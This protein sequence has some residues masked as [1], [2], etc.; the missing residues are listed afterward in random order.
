MSATNDGEPVGI[1]EL[2]I[3]LAFS[4]TEH[5]GQTA[6]ALGRSVSSIQRTVRALE[7]RLGVPLV[8]RDGRRVRLLHAGR[9][10]A[11]HA[12]SVVRARNE[13]VGAV[14]AASTPRAILR[15]GH[16]FSLGLSLVPRIVAEVLAR[17][18]TTRLTLRHGATNALVTSLLAGELDAVLVSPLPLAADLVTVPLFTEPLLF[19]IAATDALAAH[20]SIELAAVRDRAFVALSE[21]AGSRYDLMQVCA[22]AGFTPRIAIEVGDMYTLEGI[23]GAGLAVSIVPASMLH[24]THPTVVRIPLRES[25]DTQRQV[26]LVYLRGTET[27]RS[28][29]TLVDA[30]ARVAAPRLPR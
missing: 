18:P 8:E 30:A 7:A 16:M 6:E 13:V 24:H 27:R 25:F 14:R 26:G 3:F 4:R 12:A 9:V 21:G 5:L 22:R 29:G 28:V 1:A 23:V 10:L 11:D 20:A 2:E 15:L 19:A 17:D